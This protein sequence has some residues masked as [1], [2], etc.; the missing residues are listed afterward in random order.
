MGM[1]TIWHSPANF[2][3]FICHDYSLYIYYITI[4]L[5]LSKKDWLV[6]VPWTH[7]EYNTSCVMECYKVDIYAWWKACASF[8][9]INLSVDELTGI[10]TMC[11]VL[12][13]FLCIH[14]F[15]CVHKGKVYNRFDSNLLCMPSNIVS[16]IF[17]KTACSLREKAKVD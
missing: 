17:A 5:C 7:T 15:V 2:I 8:I 1:V 12:H 6:A 10:S 16:N 3:E 13:T 11:I 9:N 14:S 4:H